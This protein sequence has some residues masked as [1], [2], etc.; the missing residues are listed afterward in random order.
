M[1]PSSGRISFLLGILVLSATFQAVS[2][3]F[4]PPLPVFVSGDWSTSFHFRAVECSLFSNSFENEASIAY[5]ISITP[6]FLRR[7]NERRI[8]V[9][10][11][12]AT[13]KKSGASSTSTST[14][15]KI[16]VKLLKH[17]AGIGQ[18][19]DVVQVTP[20]FYQNK[21]RP[22][23]SAVMVT[24]DQVNEERQRAKE[25]EEAFHRMA[26]RL[27]DRFS[28][29]INADEGDS[30]TPVLRLYRKA[31]PG[32]QLFGGIGP[33]TIV[34]ELKLVLSAEDKP[35]DEQFLDQKF[36]KITSITDE[37][38]KKLEQIK[39][40]GNAFVAKLTLI[41]DVS[42]DLIISVEVEH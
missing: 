19:G 42:V 38:G 16:Q 21:L 35:N 13:K 6:L 32:G 33:K 15:K 34:D 2:G 12:E 41:K 25:Q 28:S 23:Q 31:G 36:V 24:E 20:A 9:T 29:S 22:T 3:C 4:S 14:S 17:M 8:R 39:H 1:N 5:P 27:K 40:L 37:S 26:L 30:K 11:L 7:A 10:F 18:A